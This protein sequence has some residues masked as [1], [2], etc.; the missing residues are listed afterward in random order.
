MTMGVAFPITIAGDQLISS[1]IPENDHP[2]WDVETAYTT[3]D[4][5]IHDHRIWRALESTTGDEPTAEAT[6]W[7]DRGPTNRFAMFD[8]RPD[9][10]SSRSGSIGSGIDSLPP[11]SPTT[12]T[13][14]ALP[15]AAWAS[16]NELSAPAKSTAAPT[17]PQ[18]FST[19]LRASS[20]AGS[21]TSR[22]SE[23]ISSLSTLAPSV[24]VTFC[25]G[26]N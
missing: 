12:A 13:A 21:K 8:Q 25:A 9:Y 6:E 5:V 19:A 23:L 2:A 11:I 26:L 14:P 7:Q 1:T 24:M 16:A 20:A 22:P 3:G 15:T 18:V 4:D 17:G 10:L